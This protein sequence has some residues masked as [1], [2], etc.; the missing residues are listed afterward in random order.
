MN[1][2]MLVWLMLPIAVIQLVTVAYA[3]RHMGA[4]KRSKTPHPSLVA[5]LSCAGLFAFMQVLRFV[6]LPQ[7][8]NSSNV[9]LLAAVIGVVSVLA[10]VTYVY[11]RMWTA[12]QARTDS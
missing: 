12:L 9:I 8:S 7:G 1:Q 10:S 3:A 2:S 4:S 11:W 6:D 5:S